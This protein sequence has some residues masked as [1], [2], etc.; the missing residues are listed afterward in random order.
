M[1]ERELSI[2][3]CM[4]TFAAAGIAIDY[5]RTKKYDRNVLAFFALAGLI[6]GLAFCMA[7]ARGGSAYAL[8]C[9]LAAVAL[10]FLISK[11]Y[12][13]SYIIHMKR[14]RV[15]KEDDKWYEEFKKE[16]EGE[17][18]EDPLPRAAKKKRR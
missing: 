17:Q 10:Y 5:C 16:V 18:R 13:I 9:A 6:F 1:P 15:S 7:G 14:E 2:A 3:F 8:P 4:V 11:D 12:I